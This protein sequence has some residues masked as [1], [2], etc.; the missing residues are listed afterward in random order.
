MVAAVRQSQWDDPAPC[1]EWTVREPV[2][3]VVL[4]NRLFAGVR[5]SR[6]F[7]GILSVVDRYSG[8]L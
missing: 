1:P 8:A 7:F 4:G 6:C 2:N 5:W 3:H